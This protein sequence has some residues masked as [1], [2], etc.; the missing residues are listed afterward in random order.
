MR[1]WAHLSLFLLIILAAGIG[2][3]AGAQP[4]ESNSCQ[5]VVSDLNQSLSP[6]I[7]EKELVSV[8]RALNETRNRRLPGKFITKK[9]AQ[10]MGWKPGRDLWDS[11]ALVGKSIGG[12]VFSNREGKLPDGRRVWREADLDYKGGHRGPKRIIYSDDGLRSVTVDHYN[13]FKEVRPCE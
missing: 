5:T 2:G 11:D 8:L 13:T 9:Q 10:K 7:D 3:T 4:P 1:N 12:D 6:K